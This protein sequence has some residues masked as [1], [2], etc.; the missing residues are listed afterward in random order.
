MK[1]KIM[2]MA[3]FAISS[4]AFA[5]ATKEL[6]VLVKQ[7]YATVGTVYLQGEAFQKVIK[8]KEGTG[9]AM[10][11]RSFGPVELFAGDMIKGGQVS[12]VATLNGKFFLSLKNEADLEAI[13]K[14]HGLDVEFT[15]GNLAILKAPQDMELSALLDILSHDA[16]VS[17]VN[18]EKITNEMAPE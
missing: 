6:P 4:Q 15:K 9:P 12:K 8:D 10:M 1:K 18:L 3:I 7:D 2:L 16:R 13:A 11:K 17:T 5:S 14:S